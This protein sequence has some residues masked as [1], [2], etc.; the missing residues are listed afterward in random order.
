MARG[1]TVRTFLVLLV[2]VTIATGIGFY[3]RRRQIARR[4]MAFVKSALLTP[5][6]AHDPA[7]APGDTRANGVE[8]EKPWSHTKLARYKAALD[9]LSGQ[10]DIRKPFLYDLE[11]R[12]P[13]PE[14]YNFERWTPGALPL[15][16]ECYWVQEGF[17]VQ[18]CQITLFDAEHKELRRIKCRVAKQSENPYGGGDPGNLNNFYLHLLH[19]SS[20]GAL[21][22]NDLSHPNSADQ[23]TADCLLPLTSAAVAEVSLISTEDGA[24][25]VIPI[26]VSRIRD[27]LAASTGSKDAL[28]SFI[29]GT[30]D[31]PD[32]SRD[33]IPYLLS[34]QDIFEYEQPYTVDRMR[35]EPSGSEIREIVLGHEGSLAWDEG[36]MKWLIGTSGSP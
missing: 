33:W 15:F 3:A 31:N 10:G 19:H 32:D 12:I 20:V 25:N 11:L 29:G 6:L 26:N 36:R 13:V 9:L 4:N 8:K 27:F 22:V 23:R 16:L 35:E 30:Y 14:A 17:E 24:G 2:C 7:V 5:I 1:K 18:A 34:R 21:C 28:L